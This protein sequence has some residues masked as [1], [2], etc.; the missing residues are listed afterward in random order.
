[1]ITVR[2]RQL[3]IPES[4]KQIGTQYDNNSETRRFRMDR[5][6]LGGIDLA[7]LDYHL[8]LRY[9][10][11]KLDTCILSKEVTEDKITLVWTVPASCVQQ[12]GT[13]WVA[14][15]GSD[16][17]GTVKWAS[18]QGALYVG[19]TIDTP[20][21][22]ETGLSELEEL[23]KQIEQKTEQLDTNEKERQE[24]EAIRVQNE[25]RRLANEAFWQ[26]QAEQAIAEAQNTLVAAN[27]AKKAAANSAY[28]A[29]TS[30][31]EAETAASTAEIKAGEAAE[32][33][34]AAATSKSAAETA[35]STAETKAGEAA[36][37]A[38]AA[39]S[40]RTA[41]EQAA[42]RAEDAVAEIEGV[43][44]CDGTAASVSAIDSQALAAETP[45]GQS[46]V[47]ALLDALA[48]KIKEELV[49]N[50]A[51]LEKLALY[52]AKSSIVN[53]GLTA[54]DVEG[55][56]LD[57]RQANENIEGTL[58]S[59]L[60]DL[61]SDLQTLDSEALKQV[62]VTVNNN[63]VDDYR[64]G[65]HILYGGNLLQGLGASGALEY[66]YEAGGLHYGAQ[67]AINYSAGIRFRTLNESKWS[68]W[69]TI[70]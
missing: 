39:D 27:E 31:S 65:T 37:S 69:K 2:G 15:R 14:L 48:L 28:A 36:D 43:G 11:N 18:N 61:N 64:F 46:T 59:K 1:M 45:G 29:A 60:R 67:L 57:A 9:A 42:Q 16:D 68:A 10:G 3:V 30:K 63:T 4:D 33:A 44:E 24:A 17:F 55:M 53:N 38:S 19:Q 54:A 52:V 34:S 58:A 49:T 21:G 25:Q 47:Q 32:S 13:V 70:S 5:L 40:S 8:D 66:Q 23:E 20:A 6:T 26:T 62:Y 51:L 7:N 56:V 12:V 22:V 41:A 50:E 35:A